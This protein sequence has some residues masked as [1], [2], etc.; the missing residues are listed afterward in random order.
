MITALRLT[1][2][3]DVARNYRL[4]LGTVY[5]LAHRHHWRR[6]RHDGRVYYDLADVDKVLGRD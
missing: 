4:A 6:L 3:A 2:A 1:T 5:V